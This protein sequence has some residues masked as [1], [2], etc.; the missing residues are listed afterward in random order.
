MVTI[1]RRRRKPHPVLVYPPKKMKIV[2]IDQ[3]T[4]IEVPETMSDEDARERYWLRKKSQL[5]SYEIP[6]KSL[7][8]ADKEDVVPIEDMTST[9]DPPIEEEDEE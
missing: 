2:R 3:H 1:G 6:Y 4:Q 9:E 5:K 8:D 7:P